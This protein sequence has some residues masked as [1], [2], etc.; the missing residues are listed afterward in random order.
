MRSSSPQD[1]GWL[2]ARPIAHRGLHDGNVHVMEN[3]LSAF[4]AAMLAGYAIECDVMLSSDRVP[5]V[6][7]DATLERVTAE[8]GR[9]VDRSAGEL[10]RLRL[11]ST[12]DT[13]PTVAELLAL[14]GGAVPI[15]I[16]MKGSS[17][18][19]DRDL[20]DA[21][22]P[23][24]EAYEGPLALMSFD[25]WLIDQALA[26]TDLPVGLTA[27]SLRSETLAE[28]R[29]VFERGCRFVS[30][31]VHH[32]PNPF[33]DWVRQDQGAPVITWTVRT[34]DDVERTFQHADQM[35]FEGFLPQ[36]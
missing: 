14:V 28:H 23:L 34:P 16:E 8:T 12:D 29:A 19:E 26:A 3:S 30:Y 21:L 18:E 24:V 22:S 25:P 10:G 20:F 33:V 13:V 9:T 11:G 4:R 15:V 1:L 31:N 35:T 27:E 2:S 7:H 17:A 32:L 36:L 5:V 6:F